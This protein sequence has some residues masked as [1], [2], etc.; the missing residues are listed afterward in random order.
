MSKMQNTLLRMAQMTWKTV[1]VTG[2]AKVALTGTI[3]LAQGV[4]IAVAL[5]LSVSL[6]VAARKGR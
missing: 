4:A 3:T 1:V 6:L 5:I 2:L